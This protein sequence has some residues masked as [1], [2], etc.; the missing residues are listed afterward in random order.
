MKTISVALLLFP[1]FL[2]A[3]Q[4]EEWDVYMSK[5]EKGTGSTMLNMA[6]KRV[7]PLRDLPFVLVTGVTFRECTSDGFPTKG[8]FPNLYRMSDSVK[9]VIDASTKNLLAGSFTY[10]CQRLD[11]YYLADT[12]G[13]RSKLGNLYATQFKSYTPYSNIK[14]QSNFSSKSSTC[15]S[16]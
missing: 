4:Q 3:Q 1:I 7:A 2:Y 11:Y 16:P 13:I 10:Q 8:E 12:T 15:V 5:H 9:S 6:L 14:S